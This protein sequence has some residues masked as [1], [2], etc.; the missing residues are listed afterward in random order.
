MHSSS[1]DHIRRKFKPTL[2]G[3]FES[4][5]D[6]LL[7]KVYAYTYDKEVRR[8]PVLT[9]CRG[10]MSGGRSKVTLNSISNEFAVYS[11]EVQAEVLTRV[12]K[13]VD[14]LT[15]AL[16]NK[17]THE[18]MDRLL[19]VQSCFKSKLKNQEAELCNTTVSP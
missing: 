14:D 18:Q 9:T 13:Y 6:S 2:F 19:A 17:P 16:F 10:V 11:A 8:P 12:N 5:Y 3:L 4:Q 7:K 1:R 15:T